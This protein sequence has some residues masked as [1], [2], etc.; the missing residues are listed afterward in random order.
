MVKIKRE[1]NTMLTMF[2]HPT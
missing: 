2:I 1:V